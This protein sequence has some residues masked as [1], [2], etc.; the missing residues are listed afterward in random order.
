MFEDISN[1]EFLGEFVKR[2]RD[3]K[4]GMIRDY[5]PSVI[6]GVISINLHVSDEENVYQFTIIPYDV[7]NEIKIHPIEKFAKKMGATLA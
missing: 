2:L 6:D 3:D 7:E 4:I 1:K 5:V